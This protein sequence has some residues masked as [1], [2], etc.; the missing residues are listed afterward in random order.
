MLFTIRFPPTMVLP[1]F[2]ILMLDFTVNIVVTN[3]RLGLWVMT[4]VLF[5]SLDK[6]YNW[7]RFLGAGHK[8]LGH[9]HPQH[10]I[11]I[12]SNTEE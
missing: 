4:V 11:A 6:H 10:N 3:P 12:E 7:T 1:S 5:Q 9:L 2:L 8:K